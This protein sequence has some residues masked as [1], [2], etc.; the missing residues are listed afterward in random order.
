MKQRHVSKRHGVTFSDSAPADA[1]TLIGAVGEASR[2]PSESKDRASAYHERA[3]LSGVPLCSAAASNH[4]GCPE[5]AP[6][7]SGCRTRCIHG[8]G[9]ASRD[10]EGGLEKHGPAQTFRQMQ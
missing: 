9:E 10:Q 4:P 3:T 1:T 6:A 7:E 2:R 8:H 5:R